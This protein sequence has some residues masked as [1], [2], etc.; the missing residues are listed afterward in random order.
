M[1]YLDSAATQPVSLN[2][3]TKYNLYVRKYEYNPSSVYEGGKISRDALDQGRNKIAKKIGCHAEDIIFTSGGT[4]GNNIVIQGFFNQI[5][6]NEEGVLITTNIE[7]PSVLNT[8]LHIEKTRKNIHVYYLP[9]NQLGQIDFVDLIN[10]LRTEID[11]DKIKAKNILVSIQWANNEIGTCQNIPLIGSICKEYGVFL[12]S[13][14]VQFIPHH[15][16]KDEIYLVDAFTVSGHKFGAV[17]GTG[18]IYV[19]EELRNR[20]S[21]IFF[22]GEQE[23][24]LRPGTEN[25]PGWLMMSDLVEELDEEF[26]E[27]MDYAFENLEEA[28]IENNINY[29]INGVLGVPIL[30]ITFSGVL[31][32]NLIAILSQKGIYVSAGSACHSYSPE[33]S[34]VLKAIGLSDDEASCTIRICWNKNIKYDEFEK[35]IDELIFSIKLLKEE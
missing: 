13:D 21:P 6:D 9:V 17:R 27:P 31:A 33:P 16:I 29:R 28:L 12:H 15:L 18:F 1:I 14:A 22:G 8:A 4:E 20:L 10:T 3:L 24:K 7:H 32:S 25:V 5:P 34:H 26:F 30:S 2:G 11:V 35:F 23:F 19:N